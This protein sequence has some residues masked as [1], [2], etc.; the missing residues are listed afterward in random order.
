[1]PKTDNRAQSVYS[2]FHMQL[3]IT[4][5]HQI[6]PTRRQGFKKLN[7]NILRKTQGHSTT[8]F[9][10][11]G[12]KKWKINFKYIQGRVDTTTS[13]RAQSRHPNLWRFEE[14]R[15]GDMMQPG[16]DGSKRNAWEYV[17]IVA[18]AGIEFLP[19]VFH[20]VEWTSACKHTPT[21]QNTIFSTEKNI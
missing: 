9:I 7:S 20:H 4:S 14:H 15:V 5:L 21:L 17:R 16:K 10:F 1:M 3:L 8:S 13:Q 12:T 11:K 19:V 18:L 2:P 6:R